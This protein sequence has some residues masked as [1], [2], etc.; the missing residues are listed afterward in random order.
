MTSSKKTYLNRPV[1][2]PH[3]LAALVAA[4]FATVAMASEE[5]RTERDDLF[6]EPVS[7]KASSGSGIK[8]FTQFEAARTTASPEHW[9]KLRSRTEFGS[10]VALGDG[11]KWKLDARFFYDFAYGFNY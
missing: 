3:S 8:G 4:C 10:S 7:K 11:P 2:F 9:S 1:S 5:P 6:G